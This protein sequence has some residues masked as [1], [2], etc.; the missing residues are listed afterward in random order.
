MTFNPMGNE[1][2]RLA[3]YTFRVRALSQKGVLA[4][5]AMRVVGGRAQVYQL[6]DLHTGQLY[7]LKVMLPAFRKPQLVRNRE[8]LSQLAHLPGYEACK[9][10]YVTQEEH[11]SDLVRYPNLLF[12]SLMPWIGG[13]NWA[14]VISNWSSVLD[15]ETSWEIAYQLVRLVRVLERNGISHC[16]LSG[17]NVM[18][19]LGARRVSLIDFDEVYW[20]GAPVPAVIPTG[21]PGYRRRVESQWEGSSDRFSTA[22]LVGEMLGWRDERVRSKS[23][24]DSFFTDEDCNSRDPEKFRLMGQFLHSLYPDLGTL[25]ERAWQAPS[26][27]FCPTVEEWRAALVAA[28]GWQALPIDPLDHSRIDVSILPKLQPAETL[29]RPYPMPG[30]S[31]LPT[32]ALQRTYKPE[33]APPPQMRQATR[34]VKSRRK[35]AGRLNL[36]N[37]IAITIATLSIGALLVGMFFLIFNAGH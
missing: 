14:T 21:T 31:S 5:K 30:A 23:S 8:L 28:R 3:G 29:V 12:A 33:P 1:E 13:V 16:D 11:S 2:V 19:N 27:D 6:I 20:P 4:N 37:S 24:G 9:Q 17:G 34:P 22:V 32:E 15:D 25:F 26:N 10:V 7:A 18:V 35:R 36:A